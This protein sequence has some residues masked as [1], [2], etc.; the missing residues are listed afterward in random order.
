MEEEIIYQDVNVT[1]TKTRLIMAGKTYVLKNISSVELAHIPANN[2]VFIAVGIFGML[3]FWFSDS[4][5]KWIGLLAAVGSVA[6]MI[7]NPASYSVRLSSTSG[8]IDGI[9]SKDKEYILN[10]VESVNHA[11]IVM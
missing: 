6:G 9:K 7:Y 10:I 2:S 8:E 5:L 4:G 3:C 1:I 11:I